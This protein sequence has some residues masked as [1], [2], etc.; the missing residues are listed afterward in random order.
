MITVQHSA[1]PGLKHCHC[2]HTPKKPRFIV[3]TG[4]PGAGKTA[5]LHL[6]RQR[7]CQHVEVLEESASILFGG[8]FPRERSHAGRRAAQRAIY[9]IQSEL[10]GLAVQRRA[11]SVVL[12]DRGT[13]DGLAYWPGP[14]QRYFED[15]QTT[16]RKEMSHYAMVLHLRTPSAAHYT[17]ENQL[18]IESAAE[19]RTIDRRILDIWAAHPDRHVIAANHDFLHKAQEALSMI[20]KHL[21]PCCYNGNTQP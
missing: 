6:A 9:H 8:G 15:L 11:T 2:H 12:C 13:L 20:E 18:R 10:E 19:A 17:Q 5:V 16:L 4:G 7:F 21:P 1:G 3:L 14:R